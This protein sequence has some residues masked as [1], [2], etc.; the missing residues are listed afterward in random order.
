MFAVIKTGGKQYKVQEGQKISVE[1]LNTQE[2]KEVILETLLIEKDKKTYIQNNLK[3]C[4]TKAKVL[5][6][7]KQKK[8]IVFK[9]KQRKNYRRKI[10]HRQ[11]ITRIEITHINLYNYNN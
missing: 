10:G 8:I 1:K 2:G 11:N 9:K 5:E 4:F 6:H 7:K 3:K